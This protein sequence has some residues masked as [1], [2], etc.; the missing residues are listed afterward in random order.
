MT[1]MEIEFVQSIDL[2]NKNYIKKNWSKTKVEQLLKKI[3]L[4]ILLNFFLVFFYRFLHS[5]S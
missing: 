1:Y 3:G 2:R 5:I 4:F